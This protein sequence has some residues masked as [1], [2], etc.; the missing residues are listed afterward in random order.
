MV[1]ASSSSPLSLLG[2]R[3]L[4]STPSRSTS[5]VARLLIPITEPLTGYNRFSFLTSCSSRPAVVMSDIEG[6]QGRPSPTERARREVDILSDIQNCQRTSTEHTSAFETKFN[7]VVAQY[8]N[9]ATELTDVTN[10]QFALL[11][12]RNAELYT[13]NLNS[14]L[15]RLTSS[16][17]THAPDPA[18]DVTSHLAK[19]VPSSTRLRRATP[20]RRTS[21]TG[22]SQRCTVCSQ[23]YS[24]ARASRSQCSPW[25]MPRNCFHR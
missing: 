2:L 5:R 18:A 12:L 20:T 13:G 9:Q 7:S 1:V 6:R 8:T 4:R 14:L 21:V 15:F 23:R 17:K 25:K 19:P 10:R 16:D 3:L 24:S 22:F 11:M